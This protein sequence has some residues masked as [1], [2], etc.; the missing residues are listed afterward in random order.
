M[1]DRRARLSYEDRLDATY[2]NY[3]SCEMI[4]SC[5]PGPR[6]E[7]TK[8]KLYPH[9]RNCQRSWIAMLNH[10]IS[11]SVIP[12]LMTEQSN[13]TENIRI[14]TQSASLHAH[15]DDEQQ[16]RRTDRTDQTIEMSESCNDLLRCRCAVTGHNA[17]SIITAENSVTRYH[18]RPGLRV[19]TP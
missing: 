4:K 3:T 18:V 10:L 5:I 8:K 16:Q 13:L 1:D 9:R 17:L 14:R 12:L 11:C 7:Q 6:T 19:M 2:R 15:T